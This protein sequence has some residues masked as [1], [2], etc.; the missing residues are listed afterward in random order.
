MIRFIL[1]VMLIGALSGT[2]AFATSAPAP[3]PDGA[4]TTDR[5]PPSAVDRAGD[6]EA[7]TVKAACN[8]RRPSCRKRQA[9]DAQRME[10]AK[11]DE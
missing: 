11:N 10:N 1:P 7:E 2:P 4:A 9:L 5:P 6:D 8:P 3:K